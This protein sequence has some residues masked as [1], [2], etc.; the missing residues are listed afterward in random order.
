MFEWQI[1]YTEITDLLQF[2]TNDRKSHRQPQCTLQLASEVRV[3]FVW[4]DL[5]VSLCRQQHPKCERAIRLVYPPSFCKLRTS[6][7]PTNKKLME[8]VL[9]RFKQLQLDNRSQSQ[10]YSHKQCFFFFGM[11]VTITSINID[12]FLMNH[13]S[14]YNQSRT[15]SVAGNSCKTSM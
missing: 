3:L 9:A 15:S 5:H 4:V 12:F 7:S 2:I 8:L 11:T 6:C 14:I 1:C 13:P 10:T